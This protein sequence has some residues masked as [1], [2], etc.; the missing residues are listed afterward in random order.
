MLTMLADPHASIID[1]DAITWGTELLIGYANQKRMRD[2]RCRRPR[3][4]C[5]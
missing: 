2:D 5:P 1:I 3:F 4:S